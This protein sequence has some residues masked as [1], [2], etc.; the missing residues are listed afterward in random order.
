[1]AE[2]KSTLELV[3]ERAA[4][5]AEDAPNLDSSEEIKKLG[6]R[7][8]TDFLAGNSQ[9]LMAEL[10]KHS[11]QDQVAIREGMAKTLLRNVVLPRDESL[12]ESGKKA[13]A[14]II[15]LAGKAQE[16]AAICGELS[17]ILDQ[18]GQHKEQS[19]EQLNG[20]IIGQL[21]QQFMA[22]GQEMPENIN[23]AMHPQYAE[24]LS[25]ML[26]GLNNQYNDAMDERKEMILSRFTLG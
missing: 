3:L 4:K 24:E 9:S 7:L 1:M 14:G 2:I 15:E 22:T 20:A 16:V 21:Q 25:K 10:E 26:S 8:A 5:M 18:Y 6:M 23:P 19:T 11:D 12:Q 17:Q 13:L